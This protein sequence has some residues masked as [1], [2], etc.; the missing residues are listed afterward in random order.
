[1]KSVV[2]KKILL[3]ILIMSINCTNRRCSTCQCSSLHR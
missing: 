1:M 2:F 3:C